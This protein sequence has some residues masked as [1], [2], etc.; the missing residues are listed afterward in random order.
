MN[1]MIDISALNK[2]PAE[3]KQLNLILGDQLNHDSQ[4]FSVIDKSN[5]EHRIV[6]AEVLSESQNLENNTPQ[7]LSSKQRT[8]LFF[9]AM[10]HFKNELLATGYT[11]EYTDITQGMASFS[12]VL[13][14][15]FTQQPFAQLNV[16]LPGD[17]QIRLEL[18]QWCQAHNVLFKVLADNHFISQ[19]GEFQQWIAGKKQPRM[20]YWYR[21][22][23]KSRDILMQDGKPIG[24]KWN[25]D[26]DNRKKFSKD[27]PQN[28]VAPVNLNLHKDNIVQQVIKNCDQYLPNLPGRLSEFNWPVNQ[29]QALQQLDDF[30]ENRLP[31]FGDY[32]DAMWQEQAFL[33]HSL[34]SSSLN[35][36]L[37]NPMQVIQKA[38]QAYLDNQAPLNAVEGFIRQILG[39]REYVR[40]LYWHQKD[41]WLSMNHLQAN[42]P[43]PEFYWDANTPMNCMQQSI[44]QV[45]DFGYGHHIQRLMVT[46]LFGL[47]YGVKPQDIEQWYL[48]MYVDAIAWVEQPNTLGMSQYADGGFL[49][50]KP[51]IASGNYIN[52]MSNYCKHCQYKPA[53][54]HGEQACPFTTLY[55]DFIDRHQTLISQNPR[56]GMQLKNWQN[57][58]PTEQQLIKQHAKQLFNR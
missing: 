16:V 52:R 42:Q 47:L 43:L 14:Q 58:P 21:H 36:K 34:I 7:R 40:G 55:W 45:L 32:Q 53:E 44:K 2:S 56:L 10:R 1:D 48:A 26:A 23:R 35:L 49:A 13:T 8:V 6:M 24:G 20:E 30:I 9:S 3:S 31:Y 11:V 38:Q 50:S 25:Y 5:P 57:K 29:Q 28:L 33:F 27:G 54:A 15:T 51:Y 19:P 18:K 41:H 12:E 4:L 39:W 46:G 37:L 17:E 22:L